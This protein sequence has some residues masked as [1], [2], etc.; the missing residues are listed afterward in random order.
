[1]QPVKPHFWM[2]LFFQFFEYTALAQE[3]NWFIGAKSQVGFIIPHSEDLKPI[4][5]THP[6][7]LNIE[8]GLLIKSKRAWAN[9]N[10]FSKVGLS[11]NYFNYQNPREL[12]NS[13]NLVLFGEPYL[14]FKSR[15]YMTLRGGMGVTFLDQVYDVTDNPRNTFYSSPISFLLVANIGV[16]YRL[17][18]DLHL[19]LAAN[20]N[21]ISNGGMRQPNKG[22]NFPTLSLGVEKH[23]GNTKFPEHEKERNFLA[24]PWKRYLYLGGS[25]RTVSADSLNE[26]SGHINIG[27]EGGIMRAVSN[28][29]AFSGGVELY[30]NGAQGET[31]RRVTGEAEPLL[32]SLMFGHALVF[33]KFSF[34]QQMGYYAYKPYEFNDNNFFQRY[35]IFYQLGKRLSTGFSLRAHGHVADFM[36]VRIGMRW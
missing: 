10:C 7:G 23:F 28:I 15:L 21:H 29:N 32:F 22:M 3:K 17:K 35:T 19:Q 30:Y 24:Q 27:V 12:G 8:S 34:T 20:Y 31:S 36:D 13:Y 26:E 9:C 1:M 14:G 18:E 6:L 4:S 16:N 25:R 5:D 33:G 2:F 11:F